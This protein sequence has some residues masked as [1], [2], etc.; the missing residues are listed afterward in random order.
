M[1]MDEPACRLETAKS[2]SINP[3]WE[4]EFICDINDKSTEMLFEVY[5][6]YSKSASGEPRFLGLSIVSV[7]DIRASTSSVH[8]LQLQA[9]PY[10]N[11]PASGALTVEVTAMH[12]S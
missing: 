5:D 11:D 4:E 12:S 3:Y 8:N 2:L 9:R 1:E 7:A 10:Y 6:G